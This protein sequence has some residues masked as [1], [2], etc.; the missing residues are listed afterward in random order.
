MAQNTQLDGLQFDDL[1]FPY[2]RITA[3]LNDTPRLVA[4]LNS[5]VTLGGK[6]AKRPGTL[7]ILHMG[8][9]LRADR[10]WIY[11]TLDTPPKL[12]LLGSFFDSGDGLWKMFYN[13]PSLNTGWVAMGTTRSLQAS[14]VAHE[15][16]ISRGL[17]YIKSVPASASADKYGTAIFDGATTPVVRL[18]GLAPPTEPVH[19]SGRVTRL[20][21]GIDDVQTLITVVAD[22]SP[23]VAVNFIIQ[24]EYEQMLVTA[25]ANTGNVDWTVTRG[26]NGTAA[27]SHG[28]DTVI[29]YRDW[30]PSDHIVTVQT[31]WKYSYSW[32]SITGQVSN[33]A[34]LETNYDLLP[35]NTGPFIDLIPK[36]TIQGHADTTNIPTIVVYRST[37]GGGTYYKLE[38]VTNTGA[39]NIT[40]YDDSL[41]TGPTSTTFADPLPDDVLDKADLAPS[42]IS[43]S[44]PPTVL[45]PLVTGIDPPAQ[46]SP[47]V[48]YSGRVWYAIG[49]VLFFSAQEELNEGVPEESFPI[50][51]RG[52]FF[53]LQYPIINL[54]ATTNALYIFTLQATFVVTGNNLETFN[55]RPLFENLGVPYGHPRSVTRFGNKVAFLSHDFRVMMIEGDADPEVISDPL[56]T[57]LI[58]QLNLSPNME[59]DIKYWGDLEKDWLVVAIHEKEHPKQSRQW[60]YDLKLR[61]IKQKHFW[62]PPWTINSTCLYS[63]R[64]AE[65]QSQRR[66]CF[67]VM[68]EDVDAGFLVRLDPT[69]RTATDQRVNTDGALY[70]SGISFY[71]QTHLHMLPA[72]N[73][74]NKLRIPGLSAPVQYLSLERTMTPGDRDPD[75]YYYLDDFWSDPISALYVEDP[76]RRDISKGYKT[77]Q[78]QINEVCYRFAFRVQSVLSV[79]IIELQ[80]YA[81]IYD[82]DSGA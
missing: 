24:I 75:I 47:V 72:G 63:G 50:G 78:A 12:Y 62:Y 32:K 82:T 80:S 28:S 54:A 59:V 58:D 76:S 30:G 48:S 40:Y 18:W 43:N 65:S 33:R 51:I 27:V 35:S 44:P 79:D 13:R 11:E 42:L 52:N 20:S 60:V 15:A 34:P 5:C 55:V 45:A 6:L 73:H 31:G 57:D 9:T 25:K 46:T 61:A 16:V 38:E 7:S 2:D 70:T 37:D 56:F 3:E 41:G 10:L 53:R 36:I 39:G 8:N 71:I 19:I 17:A 64:I 69:G 14:T 4:G 81:V 26:Y 49:N 68:N 23:A 77:M 67:F 74:A 66:M 1:F 22:F 21:T 29:I